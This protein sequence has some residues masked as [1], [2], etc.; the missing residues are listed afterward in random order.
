MNTGGLR[1]LLR[2]SFWE[3]LRSGSRPGLLALDYDGT[4]APFRPERGEA[5]PYP[6][7]RELLA[8]LP[9]EGP[10]RCV[11]VSGRDVRYLPELLGINPLPELWGGHGAQRLFA[12]SRPG[13]TPVW[14]A[15]VSPERR[16]ALA[17]A[18]SL[19]RAWPVPP[20]ALEVKACSLALHVR[21]LPQ[22]EG[23]TLL[24]AAKQ[25]WGR[26]ARESGLKTRVFDGGLELRPPG[27]DK[28]AVM[29]ALLRENPGHL[30]AYLG[31]DATDEDAFKTLEREGLSVL[32]RRE[33]RRTAAAFRIRPPEDLLLFLEAW[34]EALRVAP[35]T[36]DQGCL[37]P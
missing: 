24:R 17:R 1:E 21:G 19:A 34:L 31:D 18:E 29:H 33:F 35:G 23:D 36:A 32:V 8:Q 2:S 22:E 3:A 25:G 5:V 15:P 37:L 26:L 30:L 20:G 27:I 6:G 7:V 16:K 9:K 10:G 12:G 11:I 28:G 14:T 13:D 4:L